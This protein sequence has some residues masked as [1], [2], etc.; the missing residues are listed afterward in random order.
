MCGRACS[1]ETQERIISQLA[2]LRQRASQVPAHGLE[3]LRV[4]SLNTK[5]NLLNIPT[6]VSDNFSRG[7]STFSHQIGDSLS[8]E[9]RLM[10]CHSVSLQALFHSHASGWT[11]SAGGGAVIANGDFDP[12]P[13]SAAPKGAYQRGSMRS[14][15][16]ES[17]RFFSHERNRRRQIPTSRKKKTHRCAVPAIRRLE[18]RRGP[19]TCAER[20]EYLIR[21]N[22]IP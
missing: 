4:Q 2:K 9:V 17:E 21:A 10:K 20:N 8:L 14:G 6:L 3:I 7:F 22:R 18:V 11:S 12:A 1:V 16:H 5:T 15:S 13:G 19:L